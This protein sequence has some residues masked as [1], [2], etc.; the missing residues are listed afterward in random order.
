MSQLRTFEVTRGWK[1]P[2][3]TGG[4]EDGLILVDGRRIGGTDWCG[5]PDIPDGREWASYGPAG[6]L[7]DDECGF[8]TREDAEQAQVRE[9]ATNPDLFDRINDQAEAELAAERAERERRVDAEH[10]RREAERLRKRL[11]DDEPGPTI[12]TVPAFH[13]LYAPYDETVAV[14]D[15]LAAHDLEGEVSGCHPIRVEQRA[16]RRVIVFEEP[17]PLAQ[18]AAAM[19]QR[20]TH[21]G[22]MR[23]VETRVVT[24]VA[25]PPPITVPDRPDLVDVFAVH[26]PTQ[27]PLIDYARDVACGHCTQEA[28]ATVPDQMVLWRCPTVTAAIGD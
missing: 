23:F 16:E 28:H 14:A 22:R 2:E 17:T 8:A 25:D 19:H 13:H 11:G 1:Y 27:F 3:Y 9:Y 26:F 7:Y 15:W 12:A 4:I 18:L 21:D 6:Y 10:A 20:S 24:L 5:G